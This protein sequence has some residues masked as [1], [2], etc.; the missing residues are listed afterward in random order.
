MS[1]RGKLVD[2]LERAYNGLTDRRL[3]LARAVADRLAGRAGALV[4]DL[5]AGD[6]RIGVRVA[7]LTGARVVLSDRNEAKLRRRPPGSIAV[8]ADGA[9]LPF[10][11]GVFGGAFLVDVVHHLDAPAMVLGEL[12]RVLASH[13]P[14]IALDYRPT[15]G[16]TRLLR[17][18][19][20]VVLRDCHFRGPE[21]LARLADLLGL[22]AACVPLD[23]HEYACTFGPTA[24]PDDFR[25][26]QEKS[27]PRRDGP[28]DPGRPA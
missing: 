7:A 6:G 12:V 1:W 3:D 2:R 8:V 19:R 23:A 15:S 9:A 27:G 11:P 5:G 21:D 4:L 18:L 25:P 13:A 28:P 20:P 16:L 14:V 22:P 26:A 17:L 24:G 10:R